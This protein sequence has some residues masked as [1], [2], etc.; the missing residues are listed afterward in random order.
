ME[1]ADGDEGQNSGPWSIF[2]DSVLTWK[3]YRDYY[4]DQIRD[5]WNRPKF[6]VGCKVAFSDSYSNY[7]CR[8]DFE[9]DSEISY[10]DLTDEYLNSQFVIDDVYIDEETDDIWFKLGGVNGE[11]VPET[12]ADNPWVL[13]VYGADIELGT[14]D[15]NPP[16]FKLLPA[17]AVFNPDADGN[18]VLSNEPVAASH[19]ETINVSE[20]PDVVEYSVVGGAYDLDDVLFY[21]IGEGYGEKGYRYIPVEYLTLIP[22][23]ASTAY[24]KI[25]DAEDVYEYYEI[26]YDTPSYV[27]EQLPAEHIKKF[28]EKIEQ[29]YELEKKYVET[30]VSIGTVN[31]PVRVTGN[32]PD[33]LAVNAQLVS[34]DDVMDIGFDIK[35]PEDII[36]ALDV[37]LSL[38]GEEWQPKEGRQVA[39]SI[40]IGVL[41]YEN[42]S[43]VKMHRQHGERIDDFD[44][45]VVENGGVT[46]VTDGFSIYAVSELGNANTNGAQQ[47]TSGSVIEIE[48][49]ATVVYYA[50]PRNNRNYDRYSWEVTDTTGA[51][52]YNVYANGQIGNGGMAVRWI[53]IDALK[54]TE[55]TES[56]VK[57]SCYYSSGNNVNGPETYTIRVVSPKANR[58]EDNGTRLYLKDDVN[59]SGNIVATLVDEYGNEIEDGLEGALFTWSR[60]DGYYISPKAYGTDYSSVNIAVDHGG[61]VEARKE[62]DKF[63]PT[64][65]TLKVILANGD[66]KNAEYTVYYQSEFINASFE[67]PAAKADDY[68]FFH[69]GWPELYWKTTAP[70]RTASNTPGAHISKDIEY[71]NVRPGVSGGTSY[72]VDRAADWEEDGGTQFAELNAEAFGALYQDIITAPGEDISWEFSHAPRPDQSGWASNVSNAMYIVIGPT[73]N[74]QKL[75]Q[76]DLEKL[77]L[78]ADEEGESVDGFSTGT[79]SVTVTYEGIEYQVWFHDAGDGDKVDD[80][81]YD[82]DNNYGWTKLNGSYTV[83][84]GQY[85]T[86]LFFVSKQKGSTAINAGNLID[87]AKAGQYKTYL[88]EYYIGKVD[89]NNQLV[90]EKLEAQQT[91]EAL[92]YSYV[93]LTVLDELTGDG[94]NQYLHRIMINGENYP[95]SIRQKDKEGNDVASLYIEKYPKAA[96][97]KA[98]PSLTTNDY[99]QYEIV[100]QVYLR[101]VVISVEKSIV[102]PAGLTEE[103]KLTLIEGRSSEDAYKVGFNVTSKAKTGDDYVYNET[104]YAYITKRNPSGGYLGY[105]AVENHPKIGYEYTVKETSYTDFEGLTLKSVSYKTNLYTSGKLDD[106]K[107][108]DLT[109][110]FTLVGQ[111]NFAEVFVVNTYA[112]KQT[113]IY[114]KAV[115]NGKVAFGGDNNYMDTPTEKLGYYSGKATGAGVSPGKG[116]TFVGWFTDPEC[117]VPVEAKD[118][119]VDKDTGYFKPNAN[120]LYADEVTFYAKFETASIVINRTDANPN[121]TF[122]YHIEGKSQDNDTPLDMYVTLEC[123]ENGVGSIEVLEVLLGTYTVTECEDWSWRH[124]GKQQNKTHEENQLVYDFSEPVEDTKWLNGYSP[125]VDNVY[126]KSTPSTP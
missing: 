78:L 18:I 103:Q 20:L 71:G 113:T 119:A 28:D 4:V 11:S 125:A 30:T 46:M 2:P 55:T 38:D 126:G 114:Y 75:E 50:V 82:E 79:A 51:I 116:A 76:D 16:A 56:L 109:N 80:S 8:P 42:D 85:R 90:I 86:R 63:V 33:G 32:I 108:K 101:E 1:A 17:A 106:E 3:S 43:I 44:V 60:D 59:N 67:F 104:G 102:F 107:S 41:G 62:N 35:K 83:P 66:E 37:T 99:S 105:Y 68:S 10:P 95:Y 53:S 89:S 31:L 111:T 61:L 92:V 24:E 7:S 34:D 14:L 69:N 26:V 121:Q 112:E 12:L 118:G 97:F 57:L 74:A 6:F 98:D 27:L 65:Y 15:A 9:E 122:V 58:P 120:I 96:D 88:I 77:G 29:L 48:V 124:T 84:E 40:G 123:D 47:I 94:K 45:F 22:V 110:V 13:N 73:E 117:K 39:L 5:I 81:T 64:T 23:Q 25:M 49:G 91:G 36:I 19:T 100:M 72:G 54:V 115:G 70:G 87:S 93:P 52:H 21:D